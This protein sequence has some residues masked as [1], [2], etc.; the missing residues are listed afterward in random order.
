MSTQSFFGTLLFQLPCHILSPNADW[1]VGSYSITKQ[2][3]GSEWV[4]FKA[5]L[6][7]SWI[8][9]QGAYFQ[10]PILFQA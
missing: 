7:L 3:Y 5:A 2:A 6:F 1:L 8:L 9:V 4:V 10:M